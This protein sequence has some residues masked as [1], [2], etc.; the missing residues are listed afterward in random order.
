MNVN[1]TKKK[2]DKTMLLFADANVKA[3][4]RVC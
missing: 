1:A 2:A 3:S 4:C